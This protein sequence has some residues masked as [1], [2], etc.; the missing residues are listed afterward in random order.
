VEEGTHGT[1]DMKMAKDAI[2]PQYIERV[3][4]ALREDVRVYVL[5]VMKW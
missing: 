1:H 4:D 2:I 5:K 3:E